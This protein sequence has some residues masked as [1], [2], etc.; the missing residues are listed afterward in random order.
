[1][2]SD[3]LVSL[4][5]FAVRKIPSKNS[6]FISLFLDSEFTH[7]VHK[8]FPVIYIRY[9][10]QNHSFKTI[11]F[12]IRWL[13]TWTLKCIRIFWCSKFTYAICDRP[14][15]VRLRLLQVLFRNQC[16]D[17]TITL[18]R[19]KIW[20]G[21]WCVNTWEKARWKSR[22]QVLVLTSDWINEKWP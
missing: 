19:R 21:G 20:M 13:Q 14:Q 1:M 16:C 17:L 18:I 15:K 10:R 9:I 2:C 8:Y 7:F 6:F 4:L 12:W 22:S 3:R 5:I 11:F